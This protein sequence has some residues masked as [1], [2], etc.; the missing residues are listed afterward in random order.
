[1][2]IARLH[3]SSFREHFQDFGGRPE[4]FHQADANLRFY[5]EFEFC[6]QL[7]NFAML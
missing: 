1:M 6:L 3:C 7:Q 2:A 5:K 4:L